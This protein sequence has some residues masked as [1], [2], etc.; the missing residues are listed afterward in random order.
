MLTIIVQS[1]VYIDPIF[2]LF[3]VFNNYN[4]DKIIGSFQTLALVVEF[5]ARHRIE[6]KC[7]N[8]LV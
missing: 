1:T 8:K 5:M 6:K 7:N 3:Y 4:D 2:S